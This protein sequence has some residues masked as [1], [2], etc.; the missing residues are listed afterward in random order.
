MAT[1]QKHT[2]N[3][4]HGARRGW[5]LKYIDDAGGLPN[6]A[7]P[8]LPNARA[9][10]NAEISGGRLRGGNSPVG[11]WVVGFLDLRA[12][13]WAADD[14]VF[15]MKHLGGGKYEIRDSETNAGARTPYK[16]IAEITSWFGAYNPIYVGYSYSCSGR[17]YAED[18]TPASTRIARKGTA[19]VTVDALNVR[20]SPDD[21]NGAVVATYAKGQT[22]NYDSYIVTDGYVWLSYISNSGVRRYVAEGPYDGNPNNVWVSGGV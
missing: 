19:K 12:G 2:P 10:L 21:N 18:Y 7:P 14:H 11:I 13:Q 22:F 16:S 20:N 9:A 15:F 8:R 17:Q 1:R 4:G 6:T 5:C 3:I